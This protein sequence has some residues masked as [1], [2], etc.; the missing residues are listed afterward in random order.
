MAAIFGF[1]LIRTLSNVHGSLVVL[2][3]LENMDKAVGLS[4]LSCIEAEICVIFYPLPVNSRH[5]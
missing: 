3:D 1:S 2:P 4:L 5:L